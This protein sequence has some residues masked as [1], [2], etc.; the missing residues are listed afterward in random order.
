M[1]PP[2]DHFPKK[3]LLPKKVAIEPFPLLEKIVPG[4]LYNTTI[5]QGKLHHYDIVI[6]PIS[7]FPTREPPV[8]TDRST[9]WHSIM[10]TELI[11]QTGNGHVEYGV[12]FLLRSFDLN[13]LN[14]GYLDYP[15]R[16]FTF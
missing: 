7:R 4:T 6:D 15:H 10:T 1:T 11:L 12:W 8:L 5:I 13:H 9:A 3:H 2:L 16:F 14:K